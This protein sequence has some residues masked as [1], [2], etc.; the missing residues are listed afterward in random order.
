[1]DGT[2]RWPIDKANHSCENVSELLYI[3]QVKGFLMK[4]LRSW[5]YLTSKLSV[6]VFV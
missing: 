3:I 1:M 2:K 5:P 6:T 4:S